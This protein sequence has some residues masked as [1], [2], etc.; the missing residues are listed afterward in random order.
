MDDALG[1]GAPHPRADRVHG[2]IRAAFDSITYQKGATVI[3]MFESWIGETGSRRG[4]QQYLRARRRRQRHYAGLPRSAFRR[5]P[6][7]GRLRIF[8]IP[9]S[10]RGSAGFRR[11]RLRR[12]AQAAADA[13]AAAARTGSERRRDRCRRWQIPAC[14]RYRSGATTKQ[15]CTLLSDAS[16]TLPLSGACPRYVFANAGGKGYYLP[17]YRGDLL[18]RLARNRA[19]L[20]VAEYTSVL[21][22]L[23]SLVRA[24]CCRCGG[25]PRLGAHGRAVRATGTSRSLRSSWRASC[26]TRWSSNAD[27]NAVRRL[28]SRRVRCARNESWASRRRSR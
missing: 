12:S 19:S 13:F 5:E 2:D 28:R 3:G 24:G 27:R 21:Y 22:D 20:S 17:D 4:V 15:V 26:A 10:E 7:A 25:C 9:R 1:N 8:D 23:R 16:A 18:D 11:P 6:S 14:V